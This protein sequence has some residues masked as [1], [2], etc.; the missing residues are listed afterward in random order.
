MTID[1]ILQQ[2]GYDSGLFALMN[3]KWTWPIVESVHFLGLTLLIGSVGVFDLRMLGVAKQ[4]PLATLH[5]IIPLGVMGFVLNV[6][7]GCMFVLAAPAQ[8][9]YNPAFQTKWL[10]MLLAGINMFLFYAT[11]AKAVKANGL[12]SPIFFRAKTMALISLIA[13]VG[14]IAC[15]RLITFFRPPYHWCF[16]C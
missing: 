16:W 12:D 13:W 3:L 6:V 7:T 4:L 10:F 2:F 1:Q 14:V 15:G 9:L 5:K 11:T 8:Y